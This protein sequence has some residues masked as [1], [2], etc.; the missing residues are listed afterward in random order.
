MAASVCKAVKPTIL[1]AIIYLS[2]GME[3]VS[4]QHELT[5]DSKGRCVFEGLAI[6]NKGEGFKSGCILILCD[7]HHKSITVYGC[8]PPPYVFPESNYGFNN[9][10]I[11]PNCCPGHEV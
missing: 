11:W 7:F 3:Y 1:F 6:P 2:S 10:L 9:N 8:P 5:F 4:R